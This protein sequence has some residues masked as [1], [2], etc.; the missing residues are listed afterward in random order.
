MSHQ[1]T[2]VALLVSAAIPAIAAASPA[3]A[4]DATD[5]SAIVFDSTPVGADEWIVTLK[6]TI[7]VG[8]SWTG[9]DRYS[10][11]GYPSLSY[12]RPGEVRRFTSPDDSAS[13]ALFDTSWLRAGVVAGY[14]GGRY[15]GS[16]RKLFGI[17]DAGWS[18]QPGFFVDIWPTQFLRARFEGRYAVGNVHGLV[19]TVGLDFVLP[20][21]RFTFAIGPRLDWGGKSYMQDTFGVRPQD[22]ALN[23]FVTPY[24]A[25]GGVTSLGV[26]GS[27]SYTWSDAWTTTVFGGYSRLVSSAA[28]SP[29]VRNIGS[30][31]QFTAGFSAA[32]SFNMKALW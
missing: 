3:A 23:S 26:V 20:Y 32:Y 25:S 22:A 10:V 17:H 16:Q 28:D 21:E 15:S 11:F 27:A 24:K 4:A 14:E 2:L 31:D 5:R 13:L 30:R 19:G 8:P 12:R 9:S 1:R 6:G 29:I 7:A 18:V